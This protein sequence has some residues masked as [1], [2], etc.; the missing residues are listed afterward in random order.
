M[1]APPI[2]LH[3]PAPDALAAAWAMLRESLVVPGAADRATKEAVAA[4]VSA[5]NT[6]PYC[7]E[8]HTATLTALAPQPDPAL[9]DISAWASAGG[10]RAGATGR[11]WPF[12]AEQAPE[13][14]GTAVTFQYLNRMVNVFLGESPL[15]PTVPPRARDRA[16]RFL[17]AFMRR[18]AIQR[19]RPGAALDLLADAPLPAD[20]AWAA[21]NPCV[22]AAFARA[23]GAIDAAATRSVPAAVRDLLATELS[24]WDGAA[25][26]P[27]RAWVEAATAGLPAPE[28]AAGRLALLTAKASYQIDEA[29]VAEY[30]H[31]TPGD[32]ALIELTSWASLSAARRVGCW[33]WDQRAD[34]AGAAV[35]T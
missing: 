10:T 15:P 1:L 2:S 27:S 19:R 12:P 22:G 17:G 16:R 8:V 9:R 26:G 30:R 34:Y 25:P 5:G 21:G 11:P 35:T 6:C 33:L 31:T 32:A 13:L 18:S 28:R 24:T 20:L 14:I 29:A 7:V 3:S 23:A 4:A